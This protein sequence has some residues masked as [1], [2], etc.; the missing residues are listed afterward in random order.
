MAERFNGRVQREVLCI[1]VG[2]HRQLEQLLAGYN[3]AYNLRRQRVLGGRTPTE[4]VRER[5]RCCPELANPDWRPSPS[6]ALAT[7]MEVVASAKEV[8]Q[9]DN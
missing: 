2:N 9:P 8:S 6:S 4:L 7:A 5:L 1:T 3:T